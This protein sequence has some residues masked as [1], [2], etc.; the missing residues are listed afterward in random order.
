MKNAFVDTNII[1]DLISD[2][3][4]FNKFANEIFVKAES[5][6]IKLFTSSH[7]IA[8][9]HYILKKHIK[10]KELREILYNLLDYLTVVQIDL[11]IIKRGL[12][13]KYKDF[14]DSLQIIAAQSIEKIDCIITRNI[15]DFKDCEIPIL[16]PEEFLAQLK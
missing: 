13:S 6:K 11:Q 8:T 10:E 12:K 5:K 16:T 7:S 2:R 1:V 14:E 15:R 9:S 4:P 3:K